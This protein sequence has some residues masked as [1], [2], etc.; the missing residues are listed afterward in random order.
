MVVETE[1]NDAPAAFVAAL[2]KSEAINSLAAVDCSFS[3][4]D[5]GLMEKYLPETHSELKRVYGIF[6]QIAFGLMDD[7]CSEYEN[8]AG[9][10]ALAYLRGEKQNTPFLLCMDNTPKVKI[11]SAFEEVEVSLLVASIAISIMA[12]NKASWAFYETGT[13]SSFVGYCSNMYDVLR[14]DFFNSP[15]FT[16]EEKSA[17]YKIID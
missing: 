17:V 9:S 7:L 2:L 3:F 10:W 15:H 16:K 1:F 6:E 12:W 14:A 11:E 8:M 5:S 4:F 13:P